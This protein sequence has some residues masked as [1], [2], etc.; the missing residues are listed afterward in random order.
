M[1]FVLGW[2]LRAQVT[3][4]QTLFSLH[5]F[6]S[7]TKLL[8]TLRKSNYI[9]SLLK[10]VRTRDQFLS[11]LNIQSLAFCGPSAPSIIRFN[12]NDQKKN[13]QKLKNNASHVRNWKSPWNYDNYP[14]VV[15]IKVVLNL[16]CVFKIK[17]YYAFFSWACMSLI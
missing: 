2:T 3:S 7:L 11:K 4:F 5:A 14:I 8:K 16:N 1:M 15:A 13:L 9:C 10:C 17:L 12:D 6:C